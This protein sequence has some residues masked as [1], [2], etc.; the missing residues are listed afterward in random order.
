MDWSC[1]SMNQC[2]QLTYAL[3]IRGFMI[4]ICGESEDEIQA[5]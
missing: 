1:D 3:N 2:E 4:V 5:A